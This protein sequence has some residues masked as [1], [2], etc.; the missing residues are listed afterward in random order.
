MRNMHFVE[1][2]IGYKDGYFNSQFM[3][4]GLF[5]YGRKNGNI[6]FGAISNKKQRV[7]RKNT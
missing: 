6:G 5:L 7:S 3:Y 1:D 4:W 2:V